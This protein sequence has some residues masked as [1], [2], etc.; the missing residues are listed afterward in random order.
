MDTGNLLPRVAEEGEGLV[1]A[2]YTNT[3]DNSS[4][5]LAPAPSES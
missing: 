3:S 1:L 5:V 2:K 4:W